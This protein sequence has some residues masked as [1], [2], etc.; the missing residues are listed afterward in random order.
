LY[1]NNI[2][3]DKRLKRKYVHLMP[4]QNDTGS[5][6]NGKIPL[7]TKLFYGIGDIGNATNNSAFQFFLMIFLT[8]IALVS[9]GIASSALLIAKLWDAIVDPV[10]GWI[11]DKTHSRF[12]KRSVY[13]VAGAVPLA[14]SIVLVWFIPAGMSDASSFLWIAISFMLFGTFW[15]VTN[16]PYYSLSAELTNNY[17]ER[18]SL[19]AYR[20]I[21]AVPAYILGAALTPAIV[22][23]FSSKTTGY[24]VIGI[25]YGVI[26]A[27][28]LCITAWGIKEKQTS[29][30][31]ITKESTV[32]NKEMFST[33]L[34]KP[35]V[36]LVSAF[37]ISN[38]AFTL[39][40]TFIAYF[41]TYCM[42]MES[43][44]PVVMF[45]LLFSV[46]LSLFPW[47]QLSLRMN[48]GSAYAAGLAIGGISVALC[49]FVVPESSWLVYVAA[50]IAGIG[51]ATTWVFPWSM[52]PDVVDYDYAKT[53]IHRSGFYFGV[54]GF[55]TKATE[56]LGLA[57]SGWV[58]QLSGYVPN[59][60]QTP[61]AMKSIKLFFGPVPA[62][63]FLVS[64]PFLLWYP[65]TRKF[66]T[67]IKTI[68]IK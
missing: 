54:W 5:Q 51:F 14:V 16:V 3:N 2:I 10:F 43:K 47:K 49:Y 9:P 63:L 28:V 11:S 33:F 26:G 36:L 40:R 32:F 34:N 66:H 38:M 31:Y 17:D 46:V 61:L 52:L 25:I 37:A 45:L 1:S 13:M 42:G 29:L 56:A 21:M 55:V 59:V 57:I 50:V 65:I 48:K 12:G 67:E 18:S 39:T 58:L 64:I 68:H 20:M 23:N 4:I 8:D 24:H 6:S 30:V 19:T 53:G 27:I 7:R 44:V 41:L 35:F 60:N 15:T 62:V 22:N